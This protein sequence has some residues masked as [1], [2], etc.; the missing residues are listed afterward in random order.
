MN[1][2]LPSVA[3]VG[4]AGAVALGIVWLVAIV[5]AMSKT[6]RAANAAHLRAPPALAPRRLTIRG[7]A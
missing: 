5:W 7:N 3:A 6:S 1:R 2:A 4:L